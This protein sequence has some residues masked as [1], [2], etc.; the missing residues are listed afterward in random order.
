MSTSSDFRYLTKLS[1]SLNVGCDWKRLIPNGQVG[2]LK[3][4]S[5]FFL[6]CL[7]FCI[8]TCFQK[9]KKIIGTSSFSKNYQ[10]L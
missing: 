10:N 1:S 9:R 5:L 7:V 8:S 4:C 3:P 6:I 2:C